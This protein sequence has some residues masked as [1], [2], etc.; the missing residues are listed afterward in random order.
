MAKK[1]VGDTVLG[2]FVVREDDEGEADKTPEELVD[3][4]TQKRPL[5][6]PPNAP[7]SMRLEGNVPDLAAGRSLDPAMLGQVY[8]AAK[9]TT[10]EQERVHKAQSLVASLP[11]ETPHDVK[12]QIVEA[13]LKAFGVPIEQIVETGVEQIQALEAYTQHGARHTQ[14]VLV[15]AQARIEKLQGE[16]MEFKKL[17]ELQV[18]TQQNLTKSCNEEKVKVQR[19][20]EF[21][22][23][24]MIAKVVRDSPNLVERK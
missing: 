12:K 22:G 5:P 23:Q 6:P 11:A 24:E 4:Y 16:I 20:L 21:F 7:K 19:V 10:E 9:I 17:M 14:S 3:Q 15:D 18:S 1:S 2:W 8:Q 13:S